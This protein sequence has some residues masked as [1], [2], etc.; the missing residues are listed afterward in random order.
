MVVAVHSGQ[1]PT[2]S[3]R[4]SL[5]VFSPKPNKGQSINPRDKRR[6]S[7]LNSDFKVITGVILKRYNKVLTHTLSPQQLAVGDDRRITFGICQ[8]KDA[9][10]AC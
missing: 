2:E 8:A 4:T 6:L 10:E 7:M 9:I 5:M 3:Q 1:Q